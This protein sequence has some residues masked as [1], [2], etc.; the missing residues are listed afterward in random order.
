MVIHNLDVKRAAINPTKTDTPLL[1]DPNTPL[2]SSIA[3][4]FLKPVC[5]RD[6]QI[7]K[8]RRSIQHAQLPQRDLLNILRQPARSTEVKDGFRF[9]TSKGS[10]HG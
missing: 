10:N 7:I 2:A 9:G 8:A 5:W 6:A 4:Q 1:I 3:A